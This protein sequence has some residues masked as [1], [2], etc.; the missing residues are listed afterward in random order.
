MGSRTS[1]VRARERDGA[2][3]ARK[4]GVVVP[5]EFAFGDREA[6][7]CTCKGMKSLDDFF[8]LYSI[9]LKSVTGL[10]ADIQLYSSL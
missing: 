10:V 4:L 6:V 2:W 5:Q 7:V 8:N 3:L 1:G 9:S